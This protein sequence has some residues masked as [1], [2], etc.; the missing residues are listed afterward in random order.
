MVENGR[1]RK[2][3][4]GRI[5]E[6]EGTAVEGGGGERRLLWRADELISPP[7]LFLAAANYPLHTHPPRSTSAAALQ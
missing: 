6:D 1:A 3:A 5:F 2:E 4:R 7:C